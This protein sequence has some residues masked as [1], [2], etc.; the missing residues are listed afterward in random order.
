MYS[1]R[2]IRFSFCSGHAPPQTRS[3]NSSALHCWPHINNS[4]TSNNEGNNNNKRREQQPTFNKHQR[5]LKLSA[6]Q[7]KNTANKIY[8]KKNN[9]KKNA[10]KKILVEFEFFRQSARG[11]NAHFNCLRWTKNGCFFTCCLCVWVSVCN[12]VFF[13]IPLQKLIKC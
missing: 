2:V 3:A 13:C 11:L 10:K 8:N 12:G 6:S 5:C 9:N 4:N 1:L 7:L